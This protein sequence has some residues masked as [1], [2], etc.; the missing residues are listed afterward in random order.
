MSAPMSKSWL[1]KQEAME[2]QRE[3]QMANAARRD[4]ATLIIAKG[5]HADHMRT[6]GCGPDDMPPWEGL[7]DVAKS[8]YLRQA[9]RRG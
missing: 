3:R 7:S 9:R 8:I 6:H 4:A 5:L 1:V 2:R